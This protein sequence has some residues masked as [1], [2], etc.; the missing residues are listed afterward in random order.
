MIKEKYSDNEII[1]LWQGLENI[2]TDSNNETIKDNH[3]IWTKGTLISDIWSW[4][5][6]NYSKGL[7]QLWED[8][9]FTK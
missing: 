2:P 7:N 9:T 5:N 6:K 8:A 3:Y 4:F 1:E